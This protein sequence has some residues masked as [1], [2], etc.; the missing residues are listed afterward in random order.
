MATFNNR[1]RI[2]DTGFLKLPEGNDSQQTGPQQGS[3]RYNTEDS[4]LEFYNS[5]GEW[6]KLTIPF[7][8]RTIINTHYMAGGY[9]SSS[10]WSN[11]N[12]CNSATDATV[13]LGD[14]RVRAFNYNPGACSKDIGWIFGAGGG[15]A[16]SSNYTSG[17][18]M[19]SEINYTHLARHDMAYNRFRYGSLFQEHYYAWLNG[20]GSSSNWDEFNMTSETRTTTYGS[21]TSSNTW[22]GSTD[23]Y[24]VMWT[25]NNGQ[26]F[27]FATRTN[28]GS[29]LNPSNSHQQKAVNS[30][31]RSGNG[32]WAGNEGSYNGGYNLRRTNWSTESTS[33]TVGKP[34]GNSGE[35][36]FTMG[37][38]W[39]YMLGMYNGLQN[40]ISW[41]FNYGPESGFQ[42]SSTMEPKGHAG[43]SSGVGFWRD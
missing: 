5:R 40:N 10:A 16:V 38:N 3:V 37:Q 15:H 21:W 13:N 6:T 22:G 17:F 34:V 29:S 1:L 41:R 25:G 36:N 30:K 8:A 19:R 23:T 11:V 27:N 12:R 31:I 2:N 26:N 9:K 4:G 14:G 35:E 33:G 43:S 39:Q 18:N 24:G 42:G 28:F 20:G 32:L 7:E